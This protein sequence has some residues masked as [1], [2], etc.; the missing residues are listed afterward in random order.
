MHFHLTLIPEEFKASLLAIWRVH[1]RETAKGC[2]VFPSG[3]LEGAAGINYGTAVMKFGEFMT[4]R[5]SP[6]TTVFVFLCSMKVRRWYVWDLHDKTM[7]DIHLLL[8]PHETEKTLPDPFF[9]C[10]QSS[11]NS[12]LPLSEKK[13]VAQERSWADLS[14]ADLSCTLSPRLWWEA[15]GNLIPGDSFDYKHRPWTAALLV[16]HRANKP[17]GHE[18][19]ARVVTRETTSEQKRRDAAE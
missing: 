12:Q 3:N 14:H 7:V 15:S 5:L 19:P 11:R 9:L 2:D 1:S 4:C 10:Q 6:V 13:F 18:N 17:H 16:K 8:N